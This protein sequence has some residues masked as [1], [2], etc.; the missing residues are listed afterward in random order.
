MNPGDLMSACAARAAAR[1]KA[2]SFRVAALAALFGMK[3][4]KVT[5]VY[6][7][8][9]DNVPGP[10]Q[11]EYD[12]AMNDGRVLSVVSD[13]ELI[14]IVTTTEEAAWIAFRNNTEDAY[15]PTE[16]RVMRG[17]L[18]EVEDDEDRLE[19]MALGSRGMLAPTE[20]HLGLNVLI[21]ERLEEPSN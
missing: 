19:I 7:P 15:G 16:P 10:L 5:V 3:Q 12:Q 8:Q 13:P 11:A 17:I 14:T 21:G 6:L 2:R 1:R 4:T 20:D 18:L 9:S